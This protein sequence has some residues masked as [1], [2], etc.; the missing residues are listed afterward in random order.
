MGRAEEA[1]PAL[2]MI[3]GE[4]HRDRVVSVDEEKAYLDGACTALVLRRWKHMSM[5]GQSMHIRESGTLPAPH[6]PH[7]CLT[8]WA[9]FMDLWTLAAGTAPSGCVALPPSARVPPPV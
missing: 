3:L 8:R 6:F 1:R 9:L 4:A 5:P 2:R 7:A